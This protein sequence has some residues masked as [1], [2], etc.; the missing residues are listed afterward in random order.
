MDWA[1]RGRIWVEMHPI[2]SHSLTFMVSFIRNALLSVK[3]ISRP[4]HKSLPEFLG[5]PHSVAIIYKKAI[6]GVPVWGKNAC[7]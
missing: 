5:K 2:L 7:Y 6:I 1:V 4:H 3:S